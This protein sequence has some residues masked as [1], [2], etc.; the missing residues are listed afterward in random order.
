MS[1]RSVSTT[2]GAPQICSELAKAAKQADY[3][4]PR[5]VLDDFLSAD[6]DSRSA[7][8]IQRLIRLPDS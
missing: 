7:F 2:S 1:E 3:P 6:F 5:S 4:G 8:G